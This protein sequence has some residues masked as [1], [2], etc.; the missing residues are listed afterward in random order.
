MNLGP[1]PSR[2]VLFKHGVA[3]LERSGACEGSFELSFKRSEMND[4][5]KSLSVYVSRG[6]ARVSSIAF[7]PDDDPALA[8]SERNLAWEDGAAMQGL[9]DAA[10]GRRVRVRTSDDGVLEGEIVGVQLDSGEQGSTER[11]LLL[12]ES[13]RNVLTVSSSRIRSIEL[14]DDVSSSDLAFVIDRSRAQTRG[15]ARTVKVEVE[16]GA[17]DLRV[18]YIVP[19]P[20]WRVSYR[21]A[22]RSRAGA[23]PGDIDVNVMAWAIV[24]NPIDEDL[25][26]IALVLTTGQPV[27]FVIDLYRPKRLERAVVEE[28]VRVAAPP[29]R[30]ERAARSRG[31]AQAFAPPPA[32][33]PAT[34]DMMSMLEESDA[35]AG[36]GFGDAFSGAATTEDRGEYFE[37]RVD[38]AVSLKRG[39]S[40][41]VPLVSAKLPAK[42]ERIWRDGTGPHPD[43][44]V[45]FDNG[46]GFVLEEGPAVLLED[47][48]YAGEAMVPYSARGTKVRLGFA[49]DLSVRCQQEARGAT[50]LEGVKLGDNGLIHEQRYDQHLRVRVDSDH[51]SPV[52][53]IIEIAKPQGATLRS[54]A[55]ALEETANTYR[56]EVRVEAHAH[57]TLEVT[58]A[59][60]TSHVVAYPTLDR[61]RLADL[62][63]KKLLTDLLANEL[64]EV[65]AYWE[66]AR[67][68]LAKIQKMEPMRAKL[69]EKQAALGKQLEVLKESG[70]E[71]ELRLRY[72]GELGKIETEVQ[73][74]DQKVIA[75]TE[76]A[77]ADNQ[78]AQARLAEVLARR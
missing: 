23:P 77:E 35:A 8:L 36:G 62:L 66:S 28:E 12:R 31:M 76:R 54:E 38:G 4:V 58:F 78:A 25:E 10:R 13:V 59:Q 30:M 7:E 22:M 34:Y 40:A 27:S 18:S 53:V 33:A 71:G 56:F 68:Q 70:P 29:R 9:F 3:Y 72:V 24:H 67:A 69:R 52:A 73:A 21:V 19:A 42:K 26:K 74:I 20:T 60:R 57:A 1:K 11:T 37:Y 15:Q 48:V 5:L 46:S 2:L 32:A 14:C 16:G 50:V 39:G 17:E 65:V 63:Q 6:T 49:K 75:L 44:V 64:K 45:A 43:I 55:P 61:F 41:M 47:D 51:D